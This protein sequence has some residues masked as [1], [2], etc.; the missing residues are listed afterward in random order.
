MPEQTYDYVVV[1]AGLAGAAAVEGI[2]ERDADGSI[3][4]CGAEPDRPYHRPPLSK[5]LWFGKKKVDQIFIQDAHFYQD[6]HVELALGVDIRELDAGNQTLTDS[7]G[8]TYRYR[9]LL[10]A[11]GG[12]P[13]ALPIQ[14]GTLDGLCYFRTLEDYRRMREEAAAGKSA[15]VIGGGFIGSEMAAALS[16]NQVQVTM[17]FPEAYLVSRIFP[18]GLGQSL[19]DVFR[20]RNIQV[21]AGDVPVALDKRGSKFVT[22]TRA[23]LQI[24]ADLVIVGVGI[25]PGTQLASAAGLEVG[26]GIIVNEHLQTSNPNIFAAGDNAC[27]PYAALGESTRVEHWDNALNQGKQAGR[28]LAGDG[29]AYTYMPYFFSDLFEFGYEAVGE[30][31]A[32]LETFADWQEENQVGVV[33]YLR[34]GQVRGVMMC[35]VWDKVEAARALIRNKQRMTPA[36]LRGAIR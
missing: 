13:R 15:L 23:G 36:E 3:L 14:G 34:D 21:L 27:F 30:I 24:E 28:N 18:P 33:Y 20:T 10:L 19:T 35:N 12:T 32:R 16:A 26:N 25:Q 1:G 2:R 7:R 8:R 11:T 4:L 17:L 9:K 29:E 6:R 31:D 22:R 5:Q